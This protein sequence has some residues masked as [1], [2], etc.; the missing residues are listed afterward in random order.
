MIGVDTNILVRFVTQDDPAQSAI[1]NEVF[2]R[3][4]T[5]RE[6]GFVNLVVLVET[7]WVLERRYRFTGA[8]LAATIERM[9]QIE[10]LLVEAEQEVFAA[11]VALRNGEGSFADALIAAVNARAGCRSTLS[12]DKRALRLAGFEHP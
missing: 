12:F 6:P 7:A 4:L 8:E 1:A 9:L 3:R 10:T 5:A 11:M 2:A